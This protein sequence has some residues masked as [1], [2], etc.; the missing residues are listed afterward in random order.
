M[1]PFLVVA[2]AYLILTPLEVCLTGPAGRSRRANLLMIVPLVIAGGLS[3]V[4]LLGVT[5]WADDQG[6]GILNALDAPL[7]VAI[8]V[9]I[10][11]MDLTAYLGHRWRHQVPVLWR[12]HRAHHTDPDVDVTTTL[13]QHPLDIVMLGVIGTAA[14]LVLGPPPLAVAIWAAGSSAWGLFAHARLRLPLRVEWTMA[15]VLQTPGTHRVHHAPERPLTDSN[16]GLVLSVWDRM[17]GTFSAP[18]PAQ[19]TG[20]DTADL[21]ERQ[22]VGAMLADPWRPTVAPVPVTETDPMALAEVAG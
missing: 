10:L 14:T 2:L 9:T 8:A 20:L 16:Y 21:A 1:L 17:F 19:V 3:D 5:S 15:K 6:L 13:R 11:G 18:N 22:T 7:A 4:A 12:L